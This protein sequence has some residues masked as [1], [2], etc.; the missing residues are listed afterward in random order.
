MEVPGESEDELFGFGLLSVVVVVGGVVVL[1][2]SGFSLNSTRL[3]GCVNF[4]VLL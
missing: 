1:V 2:D 3:N 4:R